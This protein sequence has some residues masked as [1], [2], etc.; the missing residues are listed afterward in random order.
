MKNSQIF[1]N[2]FCSLIK[3][4]HNNTPPGDNI[5]TF[6]DGTKPQTT[7]TRQKPTASINTK[8]AVQKNA[9]NQ[10]QNPNTLI[11]N[12]SNDC[13]NKHCNNKNGKNPFVIAIGIII[14]IVILIIVIYA[15]L[16]K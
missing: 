11:I 9:I 8:T 15:C 12:I 10:L 2:F 6:S 3:T 16:H 13:Y 4:L 1:K 5:E 14:A 7:S